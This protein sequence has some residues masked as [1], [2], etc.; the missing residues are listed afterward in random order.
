MLRDPFA[1]H[2]EN[3]LDFDSRERE[4]LGRG[5]A[6]GEV[7]TAGPVEALFVEPGRFIFDGEWGCVL[8]LLEEIAK[9]DWGV[10]YCAGRENGGGFEDV[11]CDIAEPQRFTIRIAR[12][13]CCNR[14]ISTIMPIFM[15]YLLPKKK[16]IKRTAQ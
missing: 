11:E 10:S 16:H 7:K 2:A 6:H 12:K 1:D 9:E 13:E 5:F 14:S 3:G 8:A 15:Q 4:T